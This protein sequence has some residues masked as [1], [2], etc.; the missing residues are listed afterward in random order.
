MIATVNCLKLNCNFKFKT[1]P[2][3]GNQYTCL[4][5]NLNVTQPNDLTTIVSGKHIAPNLSNFNVRAFDITRQ[6]CLFVPGR[7][8]NFFVNLELLNIV[9]SQLQTITSADLKPFTKLRVLQLSAN[10]LHNLDNDLFE[11]NLELVKIEFRD[12]KLKLIGYNILENLNQ[13]SIGDFSNAGCLDFQV[14]RGRGGIKDLKKEIRI[15]CQPIDEFFY[16][17][18][19]INDKLNT[20]GTSG[21]N[22]GRS[23][24]VEDSASLR[25]IAAKVDQIQND[26]KKCLENF[27]SFL[28]DYNDL[29]RKLENLEKSL[30]VSDSSCQ[31][32]NTELEELKKV[33]RELSS[34]VL[35]CDNLL[36]NTKLCAIRNLKILKSDF[37]IV[38]VNIGMQQ[39]N[40]GELI[41]D[42]KAANQ[43]V[44]Y[45]PLNFYKIFPNLRTISFYKCEITEIGPEPLKQLSKLISLILSNN[46]IANIHQDSLRGLSSLETLD[47]S[48]NNLNFIQPTTFDDLPKLTVLKINNNQLQLLSDATFD[49]L[50]NLQFLFMQS[51][52]LKKIAPSLI[53]N[54]KSLGFLDL[55]DNVCL[56][57]ESSP[58]H[59][60]PLKS[61]NALFTEKC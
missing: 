22:S 27:N 26:N 61:L 40:Q 42:L 33:K 6:T 12:Q 28:N 23:E 51:N 13:L 52:K 37:E 53:D 21:G 1:W 25:K 59:A 11:N 19:K 10:S 43:Q 48:F 32:C 14:E 58:N 50:T 38:S 45:L 39:K 44:F 31:Y 49:K 46:R 35:Q 47:L 29:K 5:N 57:L 60:I 30:A 8:K 18:R 55:T 20:I 54:L 15:N 17:F 24:I 56:N 34:I 36:G 2:V 3:I 9:N 16:E 7:V 4:S 41:E